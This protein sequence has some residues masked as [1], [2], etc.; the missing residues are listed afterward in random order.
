MILVLPQ[1]DSELYEG[2]K[3]DEAV[4]REGVA[5]P[6]SPLFGSVLFPARRIRRP[7]RAAG[8]AGRW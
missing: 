7:R 2:G 3:R 5:V 1:P 4:V 8:W 6:G